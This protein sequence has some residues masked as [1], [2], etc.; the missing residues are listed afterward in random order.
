M[1]SIQVIYKNKGVDSVVNAIGIKDVFG[2]LVFGGLK[3]D[4]ST[5]LM[6][7]VSNMVGNVIL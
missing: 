7:K 1:K 5:T 2:K 6:L 4:R 3:V